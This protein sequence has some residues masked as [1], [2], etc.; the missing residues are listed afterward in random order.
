METIKQFLTGD[1]KSDIEVL[2]VALNGLEQQLNMASNQITADMKKIKANQVAT[3]EKVIEV[4][5]ELVEKEYIHYKKM[6]DTDVAYWF[7]SMSADRIQKR[8]HDLNKLIL[9]KKF[10]TGKAE[11]IK[12]EMIQLARHTP[13]QKIIE[14]NKSRKANCLFHEDKHPSLHIFED[15][16]FKCFSCGERGDVIDIVMKKENMTF[17]Q[18]INYLIK[19]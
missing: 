11:G 2:K 8:E 12:P 17:V 5:K 19:I 14:V 13:I 9:K 3:I 6:T 16:K 18:A 7:R 1:F 4:A 10:L 15:N